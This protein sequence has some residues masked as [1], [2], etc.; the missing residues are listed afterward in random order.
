NRRRK[1][2]PRREGR[3]SSPVITGARTSES[4]FVNLTCGESE[5]SGIVTMPLRAG[6]PKGQRPKHYPDAAKKGPEPGESF[7]VRDLSGVRHFRE[8]AETIYRE[9]EADEREDHSD[10][11]VHLRGKLQTRTLLYA[12][13]KRATT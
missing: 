12:S 11:Q 10:Y 7:R 2:V 6:D 9:A 8:R 3:R 13:A 1:P 5:L 4:S